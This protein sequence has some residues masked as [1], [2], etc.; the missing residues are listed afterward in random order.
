LI[1]TARR[2]DD[3]TIVDIPNS[4]WRDHQHVAVWILVACMLVLFLRLGA[5]AV[6]P[7]V[8]SVLMLYALDPAVDALQRW[9]VPRAIAIGAPLTLGV[10]LTGVAAVTFTLRDDVAKITS[11]EGWALTPALLGRAAEMN[12]VAIFRRCSGAGCGASGERCSRFR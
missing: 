5:E 2:R 11:L 6:V 9:R 3:D 10:V 4:W 8:L 7:F 12:R 1:N